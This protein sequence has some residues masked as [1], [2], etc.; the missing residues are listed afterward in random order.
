[1]VPQ[2]RDLARPQ[3]QAAADH[4]AAFGVLVDGG[5]WELELAWWVGVSTESAI[6]AAE[7]GGERYFLLV[8]RHWALWVPGLF[9]V[10]CDTYIIFARNNTLY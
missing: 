3:A 9:E 8:F 6:G 10:G 7:L 1:M 4:T 5:R 2:Y